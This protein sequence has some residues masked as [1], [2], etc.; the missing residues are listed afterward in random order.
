MKKL[1]LNALG[2]S[3]LVGLVGCSQEPTTIV[4][5]PTPPTNTANDEQLLEQKEQLLAE[6]QALESQNA[7]L[8]KQLAELKTNTE[9]PNNSDLTE[10]LEAAESSVAELKE[11]LKT[12]QAEGENTD[13]I[14]AKLAKAEQDVN[15]MQNEIA[16]TEEKLRLLTIENNKLKE[17]L[18]KAQNNNANVNTNGNAESTQPNTNN[19][20][21]PQTPPQA[22]SLTGAL[23]AIKT[24]T[25]NRGAPI[26]LSVVVDNTTK[27]ASGST[28]PNTAN[29]EVML[30]GTKIFL[31]KDDDKVSIRNLVAND[32]E[33]GASPNGASGFVGSK[34]GSRNWSGFGQMRYGAYSDGT[35]KT[36]LFVNGDPASNNIFGGDKAKVFKGSAVI[37]K[38][39]TYRTLDKKVTAVMDAS[40]TKVDVTI[41]AENE[42]LNFSGDINKD[43]RTFG[44][45]GSSGRT[46]GGFF[47]YA[48][49]GGFF[50]VLTGAHAG[51]H[52]VYGASADSAVIADHP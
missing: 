33:G 23:D 14:K 7:E 37:G 27:N 45:M 13:D 51:E 5:H 26:T 16:A 15:T 40:R 43:T 29:D 11:Q 50:E 10:K 18:E 52:G 36:H 22:I 20:T 42:T 48:E 12:A 38:D 34:Y 25:L 19:S 49:L 28:N 31:L 4:I 44:G 41:V 21:P 35:G 46:E 39:G 2:A 9:T 1:I 3:V 24:V 17:Q 30:D 8:E 47:G 32:F 6:K